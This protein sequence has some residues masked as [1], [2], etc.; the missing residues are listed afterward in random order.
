MV[1]GCSSSGSV[2]VGKVVQFGKVFPS[3]EVLCEERL[4]S[5]KM[6]RGGLR[7]CQEGK[8]ESFWGKAVF[9]KAVFI[10]GSLFSARNC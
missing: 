3:R 10:W 6:F 7:L 4:L 5:V 1:N 8:V 9:G 2:D